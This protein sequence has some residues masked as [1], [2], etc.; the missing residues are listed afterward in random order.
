MRIDADDGAKSVMLR[1]R[2]ERDRG[3]AFEASNLD[4]ET[5]PRRTGGQQ[6]QG[7]GFQFTDVA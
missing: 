4:D 3:L 6:A 2:S 7:A 5:S 1:K